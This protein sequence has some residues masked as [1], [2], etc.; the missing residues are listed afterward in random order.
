MKDQEV[1]YQLIE[2]INHDEKG[3]LTYQSQNGNTEKTIRGSPKASTTSHI[4]FL[5]ESSNQ[6]KK[7]KKENVLYFSIF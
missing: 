4:Y 5:P 2:A 7:I 1:I 6:C 3:I